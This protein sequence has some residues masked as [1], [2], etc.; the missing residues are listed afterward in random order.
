MSLIW[1]IMENIW[2]PQCH[3]LD[4]ESKM[5]L[6]KTRSHTSERQGYEAGKVRQTKR[7]KCLG[8]A[9]RDRNKSSTKP[10]DKL[11]AARWSETVSTEKRKI[12]DTRA[13]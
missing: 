12:S 3:E 9:V 4:Y 13:R 1:R 11:P 6:L 10:I 5:L 7:N 8:L 2:K